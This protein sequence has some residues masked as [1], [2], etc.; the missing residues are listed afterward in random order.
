MGAFFNNLHASALRADDLSLGYQA[1]QQAMES[2]KYMAEFILTG[3]ISKAAAKGA[4]K[5][6]E[7]WIIKNVASKA[8]RT[9]AKGGLA[10]TKGLVSHLQPGH[11]LCFQHIAI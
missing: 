4:T 6:L 1:G 8:G 9:L 2:A 11:R 7:A 10:V 5:A 3:G